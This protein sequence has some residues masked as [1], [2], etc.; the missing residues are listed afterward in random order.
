MAMRLDHSV[1][2]NIMPFQNGLYFSNN[3]KQ[4]QTRPLVVGPKYV[5][6]PNTIKPLIYLSPYN[7]QTEKYYMSTRETMWLK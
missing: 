4:T 3:T 6:T 1:V 2:T 7:C 5:F